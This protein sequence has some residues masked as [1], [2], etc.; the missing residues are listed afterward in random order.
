L[1][2]LTAARA[3]IAHDKRATADRQVHRVPVAANGLLRF[4]EIGRP[5][6]A[7]TRDLT[8]SG[9]PYIVAYRVR[10]DTVEILR[11]IHSRQRWPDP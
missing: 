6:W 3:H 10:S 5:G 11:L 4:P 9:T 1:Q 7:T 2:D 8:I